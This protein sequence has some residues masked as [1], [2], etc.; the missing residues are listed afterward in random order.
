MKYSIIYTSTEMLNLFNVGAEF[1][2]TDLFLNGEFVNYG[3]RE[4]VI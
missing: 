4:G 3:F 1:Y 2:L